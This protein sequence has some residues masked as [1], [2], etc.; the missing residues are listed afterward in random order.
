MSN[1]P[2]DDAPND[3]SN[4][5]NAT[6]SIGDIVSGG[7]NFLASTTGLQV[8][9]VVVLVGLINQLLS[10]GDLS[11]IF[12]AFE[13]AG[14]DVPSAGAPPDAIVF[15]IPGFVV[16]IV[17]TLLGVVVQT[18]K[19]VAVRSYAAD[20][21]GGIN[22][23]T[24]TRRLGPAIG[25][26]FVGGII[27]TIAQL[28]GLIAL[29]IGILISYPVVW[30]LFVF[31]L[32]EV[33]IRDRGLFEG[34]SESLDLTEGHRVTIGG[35][36]VLFAVLAL[37]SGALGWFGIF[38]L[39][40]VV[41]APLTAVIGGVVTVFSLGAV[42]EAWQTLDR[43]RVEGPGAVGP[44]NLADDQGD[45]WQETDEWAH[46]G[47]QQRGQNQPQANRGQYGQGNNP[48]GGQQ[49]PGQGGQHNPQGGRRD[50]RNDDGWN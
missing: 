9:A 42:T 48:Q 28:S 44:D 32:Q 14:I 46:G 39:P 45:A 11:Q 18:V 17:A 29:G 49:G 50:Q 19:V 33:A 12:T 31:Y 34:M 43:H 41:Y 21:F 22:P 40:W 38:F 30:V 1:Q 2:F 6:L 25:I 24:A 5:T 8:L 35:L 13:Q 7:A 3:V 47:Q 10:A 36:G 4:R 26:A 20:E 15:D 16:T 23:D 27:L 37:V